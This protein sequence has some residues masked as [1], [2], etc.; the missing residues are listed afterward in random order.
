M[1]VI[2][3]QGSDS[4]PAPKASAS[5]VL[6]SLKWNYAGSAAAMLLQ[7]GYVACTGRIAS[8]EAFGAYAIA[9]TVVQ[10]L[11]YFS[12]AGLATY[13]L[14]IDQLT[15]PAMRAAMRLGAA[16][17]FVFFLLTEAAAPTLGALWHMP[18]LVPMLRLLGCQ[19]LAQPGAS[20]TV[21]A[22][23]RVGLVR[24]AVTCEL[25]GQGVAVAV[26]MTLLACGWNPLALAVAQP[27]TA[28]VGLA[29]GMAVTGLRSPL[30]A[31]PPVRAVDLLASSSFLAG[32]SLLEFVTSSAPMWVVGRL[33]GPGV[34]GAYNRASLLAGL[35]SQLLFQGLNSSVTPLLAERRGR[36]LARDPAVAHTLYS[37]SAA[38]LICFG[39][40]AGI[41]PA[42]LS[43]L[44]GSGWGTASALVPLL[45]VGSAMT[46]L[47]RSGMIIDQV[48]RSTGALLSTQLVATVVTALAVAAAVASHSLAL[49]AAAAAVGQAAGHIVQ[50]V[51]WHRAGLLHASVALRAH[52]VHSAVGAALGAAAAV[53]AHGRP[54]VGAVAFGL[55]SMLPVVAVCVPLRTR[56][57]LYTTVVAMGLRWPSR[58]T[59]HPTTPSHGTRPLDESAAAGHSKGH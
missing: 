41:G 5:A 17:G 32:Y 49:L 16:S 4:A 31:G 55:S 46:L 52:A 25:A 3:A 23:R 2:K 15:R 39:A 50:L 13:V 54:P 18:A 35:S 7:I 28:A 30:P 21:T 58:R 1:K 14:R 20:V 44:L 33:F 27:T 42:A 43:L 19:L 10:L 47:C 37:A 36:G 6:S 26:A 53:G 9:L 40:L 22:L 45:A 29:L 34:T 11:G 8:P 24:A 56:I 57:P 51:C 48:R 59:G 38:A 12:N